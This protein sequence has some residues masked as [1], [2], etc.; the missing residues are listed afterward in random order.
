MILECA[1]H[2]ISKG[3]VT[4]WP[5]G[6]R[7]LFEMKLGGPL[8]DSENPCAQL[9]SWI[10]PDNEDE[11]RMITR[12]SCT[13]GSGAIVNGRQTQGWVLTMTGEEKQQCG[14][15]QRGILRFIVWVDPVL[16][17]SIRLEGFEG[18]DERNLRPI[19]ETHSWAVQELRNIKVGPQPASL[20]EIA[21][22]SEN[23]RRRP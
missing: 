12:I 6:E 2:F 10:L 14:G 4:G 3:R 19:H 9:L 8:Q 18:E 20:F 16:K 23:R 1:G 11:R 5:L 15:V 22:P 7:R 13:R 17:Y 21:E